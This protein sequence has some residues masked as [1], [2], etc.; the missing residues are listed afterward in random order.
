MTAFGCNY[1]G[2]VD[3]QHVI[4]LISRTIEKANAHGIDPDVSF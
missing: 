2:N 4:R 1:E 3:P